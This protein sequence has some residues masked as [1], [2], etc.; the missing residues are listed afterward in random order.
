MKVIVAADHRGFLLKESLKAYLIAGGHDVVDAGA[1]TLNPT[2]DYPDYAY[3][4]AQMV[5]AA[6]GAK[7]ILICGSGMGMDVVANKVKGIRAAIAY[8]KEAA[9]HGAA[10]DGLNIITLAA[11][12]LDDTSAREIVDVFLSTTLTPD[13]R[14]L[15]R[16]QKISAIE[17][18]QR[19]A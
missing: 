9:A 8:S 2:D 14:F 11:D 12:I 4:A 1:A 6:P 15:R 13:E 19:P 5:A 7:G 3:P 16:L 18:E 10:N 17:E